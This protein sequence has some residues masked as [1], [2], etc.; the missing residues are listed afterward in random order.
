MKLNKKIVGVIT[1]LITVFAL[2][3]GFIALEGRYNQTYSIELTEQKTAQTL[4]EVKQSIIHVRQEFKLQ[5]AIERL[6]SA[7]DRVK[8][9]RRELKLYPDDTYIRE[10]YEQAIE[11]K[12]Q[13]KI[14]LQK[15]SGD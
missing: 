3:S 6:R 13:A 9:L 8:V 15:L 5:F 10:D 4:D 7:D 11:A 14:K 12:I 2:F 1:S